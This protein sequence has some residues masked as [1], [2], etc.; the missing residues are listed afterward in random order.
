MES[1]VSKLI[2]IDGHA[3]LHRAYHAFPMTLTTRRG[4]LVNAVYGFTRMLLTVI[5]QQKPEYIATAFDT[6]TPSF[7]KEKYIGYQAKRPQ[8]DLELKDQIE[9]VKQVVRSLNIP[10]F[11]VPGFEADDVIGTL[12]VKATKSKIKNQKSKLEI[13]IVTGDKDL[14]QLIKPGVIVMTP[15]RGVGESELFDEE[16]VKQ[17][18][19]VRPD[20][21]IDY[22]A[23][24]G[25]P[26]DNYPGVNGIGPKTA[27][28]LLKN[29]QNLDNIY[30][31]LNKIEP[32]LRDK[33]REEKDEA[34]LSKLLATI[35]TKTPVKL[36]FKKCRVA[37]YDREKVKKLFEELEFRSLL[38]K[39]PGI[40]EP[41]TNEQTKL[42]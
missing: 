26:S 10:I 14:F 13:V 8:M 30:E 22:K 15:G 9:R 37:D 6:A 11:E 41:L 38:N 36:K 20:Q 17:Y 28:E 19:G 31:H 2:L 1:W 34:Y 25:D 7:R 40:E 39:L 42:F 18:L 3:I 12:V 4:E 24:V 29:F 5:D 33:L 27:I 32:K 35:V 23:L 16:K 21:I